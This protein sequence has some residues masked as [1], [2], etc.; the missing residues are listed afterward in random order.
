MQ[1]VTKKSLDGFT[2]IRQNRLLKNCARDK[3]M[4]FYNDKGSVYPKVVTVIN[5][6]APNN[7][8]TKY[9]KQKLT[10]VKG[11]ETIQQ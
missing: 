9:M 8:A 2:N 4:K 5:T 11:K 6:Q 10:E 3:K 1:S 7:G